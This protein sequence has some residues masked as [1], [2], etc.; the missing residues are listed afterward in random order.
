MRFLFL[1]PGL[2]CLFLGAVFLLIFRMSRSKQE[3]EEQRFTGRAWARLVDTGSKIERDPKERAH[4]VYF[5]IYEYDTADGQHVTSASE[6]C[7]GNE[8]GIP[9]TQGNMVQICYDPRKPA[10]F[11]L[12][13]EQ[14]VARSVWPTF[15][16]TG[17]GLLILGLLL[18]LAAA[19]VVSGAIKLFPDA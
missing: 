8:Q 16:K 14:A 12:L 9:G 11:A 13:E 1:I 17:I 10:D 4:T 15:R 2:V 6:F 18:I 7:Y 19:A 3:T 5:G